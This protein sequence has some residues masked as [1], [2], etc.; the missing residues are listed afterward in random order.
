MNPPAPLGE[1]PE[2]QV[3]LATDENPLAPLGERVG[4]RGAGHPPLSPLPSREGKE[5]IP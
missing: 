4:V 5:L 3:L 1:S 2:V